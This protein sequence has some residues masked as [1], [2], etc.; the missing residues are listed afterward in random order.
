MFYDR[1]HVM[2][3]LPTFHNIP[4]KDRCRH[5]DELSQVCKIN[6]IHN[7]L[8]DMM[9]NKLFPTGLR[10]RA[11]DWFLKLPKEFTTST[12]MEDEFL[13]KYDSVGKATSHRKG[14]SET[15]HEG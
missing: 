3:M 7:V 12:K 15:F 11:N 9:K 5:I 4:F 2:S 1:L 6:Q 13:W 10:D 14:P 8:A